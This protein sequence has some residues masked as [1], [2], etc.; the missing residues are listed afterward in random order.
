MTPE[1]VPMLLDLREQARKSWFEADAKHQTDLANFWMGVMEGYNRALF[2]AGFPGAS[3]PKHSAGRPGPRR[4]SHSVAG[5]GGPRLAVLY[6]LNAVFLGLVI[7]TCGVFATAAKS[8]SFQFWL[9]I[10][11]AL[12]CLYA[13]YRYRKGDRR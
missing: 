1:L 8:T 3:A 11:V 13:L 9:C 7:W 12:W 5:P 6:S 4:G 2:G 10:V